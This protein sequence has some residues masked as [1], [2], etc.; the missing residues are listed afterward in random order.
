MSTEEFHEQQLE[1]LKKIND[2]IELLRKETNFELR[3]MATR[4]EEFTK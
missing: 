4:L 1:I 3:R 2:N